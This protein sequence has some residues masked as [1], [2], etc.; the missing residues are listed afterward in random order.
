MA[1]PREKRE[2]KYDQELVDEMFGADVPVTKVS[3]FTRFSRAIKRAFAGKSQSKAPDLEAFS[4]F[5]HF[6]ESF[7]KASPVYTI[8]RQASTLCDEALRVA[9]QRLRMSQKIYVLDEQLRELDAFIQLSEDDIKNLRRMLDRFLALASERSILLEK[10]S[11]YDSSLPD[12]EPLAEDARAAMPT[13]KDAEKQQ[14]AL[15]MDIGY[16]TGEKEELVFEREEM[17]ESMKTIR[18]LT[19]GVLGFF[20]LVGF[21]I[22]YLAIA[23]GIDAILPASMVVVLVMGFIV[24]INYHTMK[25]RRELKRNTKKHH[26][27]I[28]LLNKKAVVYAYYTNFLKF[29]YKKYKAKSSRKIES[30]L[31]DL[32]GYRFLANRIDT[33]RSLMYE[34]ETGIEL[35]LRENKLGG[36]RST[37]EG[38]A[39][40]V[41]LEDKIKR[42]QE[43]QGQRVVSGKTLDEL[44]KRHETIWSSLVTLNG[45]D[46]SGYVEKIMASYME[47]AEQVFA[48]RKDEEK[49]EPKPVWKL[50]ELTAEGESGEELSPLAKEIV[51]G[52]M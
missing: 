13:I 14:R 44:D 43:L 11:D 30:N 2:R 37:I 29:V 42:S 16:L 12:M 17:T 6:Y 24:M 18:K 4:K 7:D 15:R 32:E 3:V 21:I 38:F 27:A 49:E 52:T 23:Q 33:V 51:S 20:I 26:R 22:G 47:E 50:F 19:I 8:I 40:T 35:F 41:N 9:N 46:K 28:E 45:T 1:V 48:K 36:V 31:Q 39:K 25:V 5:K 34:T 10:L